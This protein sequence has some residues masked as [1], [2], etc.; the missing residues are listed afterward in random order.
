MISNALKAPHKAKQDL[1]PEKFIGAH[2]SYVSRDWDPP[3]QRALIYQ[4]DDERLYLFNVDAETTEQPIFLRDEG[5]TWCHGWDGPAVLALK[6]VH[7]LGT[8]EEP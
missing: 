5:R 4:S 8:S 1:G 2:I 7:G 6:T 3:V